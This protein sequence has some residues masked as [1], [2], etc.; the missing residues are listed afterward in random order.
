MDD[1]D[2]ACELGEE[3]RLLHGGVTAA[4]DGDVLVTEEEAVAG[5]TRRHTSAEQ[6]LLAGNVEVAGCGAHGEDDGLCPVGLAAGVDL[7]DL[8]GEADRI[9]VF[10]AQISTEPNGLLTHLVHEFGTLD[11]L[12]ESREVLHLGGGHQRTTE[13]GALEDHRREFGTC[14]IHGCC[15]SGRSGSDDDHVVDGLG[16]C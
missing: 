8:A 4:D 14:G 7:F 12:L 15:V 10:H 5:G 13:L 16:T 6:I 3:G 1:G 2:T 9:H 11:P